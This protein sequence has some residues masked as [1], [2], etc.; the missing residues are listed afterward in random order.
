MSLRSV[1]LG[2][3]PTLE[4]ERLGCLGKVRQLALLIAVEESSA[5][6]AT[7]TPSLL[8]SLILTR[9]MPVRSSSIDLGISE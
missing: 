3:R 9:N 7:L 6:P 2:S 5:S 4:K 1:I 8:S